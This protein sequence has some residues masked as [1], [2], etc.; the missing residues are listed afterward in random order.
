MNTRKSDIGV[1]GLGVMGRNLAL[2][3][4]ENGY[5]VSVY[6]REAPGEKRVVEEFLEQYPSKDG[7]LGTDTIEAFVTSLQI[8]R[9]ILIMVKAGDPVDSVINQLKPFLEPTDIII[10]GGNSHYEDTIRREKALK[11]DGIRFVGMGVSGGEEGAR[12]GASLMPGGN[13]E[14]W[15]HIRKLLESIAASS[16]EGYPCCHWI[17]EEGAG[18]FV[19]MVHNGIEYADM[20]LLAESYDI[21]KHVI[22]INTEGIADLF[23]KWNDTELSGYLMEITAKILRV[24]DQ[25][26]EPLID[27]IADRASQKGTGKWT[28][29]TA[30]AHDSPL[31]GI[32]QAVYARTLSSQDDIRNVMGQTKK[33]RFEPSLKPNQV[34]EALLAARMAAYAEGFYLIRIIGSER[35]WNIDL[36]SIAR[37]WQGGCIIRSDLLRIIEKYYED[38]PELEHLFL[39]SSY[40]SKIESAEESFRLTVSEA[41]LNAVPTPALSAYLNLT[42]TLRS[43]SLPTNLIQA[44]RDYFGAHRYERIDEPSGKWFHTDWP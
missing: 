10:D 22:G 30:L 4:E 35:N 17:G 23:E 5:L 42:D 8:P 28:A 43:N 9:K 14:A 25:D 44:Q 21:L 41:V 6:N 12:H 26:G 16:F 33:K 11:E 29:L 2:N 18:H 36:S 15:P 19:K 31:P 39:D 7:F 38:S 34:K 24:K 27:K 3:L 13:E 32:T 40:F 37:I 1:F 20:Q